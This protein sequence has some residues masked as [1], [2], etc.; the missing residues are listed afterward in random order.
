MGPTTP[1]IE[2]EF[3]EDT[4]ANCGGHLKSRKANTDPSL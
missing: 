1:V 3:S 2:N 4:A